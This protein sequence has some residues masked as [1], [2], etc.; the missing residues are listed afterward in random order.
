AAQPDRAPHPRAVAAADQA[1]LRR[2]AGQRAGDGH[3]AGRAA[4]GAAPESGA[5]R[6]HRP[7]PQEPPL[8]HSF[9]RAVR[10]GPGRAARGRARVAGRR[11]AR[12]AGD[13]APGDEPARR[14]PERRRRARPPRHGVRG[15]GAAPGDLLRDEPPDRGQGPEALARDHA[16]RRTPAGR[17]RSGSARGREPDRQRLQI[18]PARDDDLHRSRRGQHGR[19]GGARLGRAEPFARGRGDPPR[20]PPCKRRGRAGGGDS[21]ARRGGGDP[22]RLPPD[23][24][25]EVRARGGGRR[26]RRALQPRAGAGVLPARRRG[27]RR[28]HLDRRPTGA[29]RLLL[30]PAPAGAVAAG[31]R[32]RACRG[33]GRPLFG[34][35]VRLDDEAPGTRR[36]YAEYQLEIWEHTD[37]M[38]LWLL[39]IQWLAGIV[40]A[41][42]ASATPPPAAALPHLPLAWK[43][44]ILGGV[45]VALPLYFGVRHPGSA[46]TRQ[47]V[48]IGQGLMAA[49]LIY[50]SGSRSEMRAIPYIALAFLAMYRDPT[51][52]L[53][54]SLVTGIGFST[55]GIAHLGFSS[56]LLQTAFVGVEALLLIVAIG[57]SQADML[58]AARKQ[59]TIDSSRAALEREVAERQRTER[60]LSLQYVITR[61]LAGSASLVEAAPLI[62]RIMGENQGWQ[63]GELW[64]VEEGEQFLRCVDL[65][66]AESFANEELLA[67]RRAAHVASGEGLAG[68]VW[69]RHLPLWIANL[70]DEP[71]MGMG[72]FSAE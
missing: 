8:Q 16:G 54:A 55:Y 23:R 68:R 15:A 14:E 69:Q 9:Q 34:V 64:E 33:A 43:A 62:L 71:T 1:A 67:R 52:L 48:A 32:A 19:A 21:R 53:L 63:V 46:H 58:G 3:P 66:H 35:S 56:W 20:V 27:A 45:C 50:L 51:V 10:A 12:L 65:W 18:R 5:H 42:W 4:G 72:A 29:R 31:R 2:A 13:G 7:R 28:D 70:A 49:L 24:L 60:L 59:A 44:F 39:V 37:R 57:R 47:E 11:G 30:R 26:A 41:L 36:L 25:R 61:A 22:G 38:F 6:P 17:S 40:T